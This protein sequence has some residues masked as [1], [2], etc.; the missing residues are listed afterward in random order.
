VSADLREP[1]ATSPVP[2]PP[3]SGRFDAFR[4][5]PIDWRRAMRIVAV[6]S[7]VVAVGRAIAYFSTIPDPAGSVGIDYRLYVAA[8]QRWLDS[9]TF[10]EPFQLAGPYH[11]QGIGEVLYPPIILWLLVPFTVLPAI[12]WWAI[13]IGLTAVAIARMRPAAWSVA[14]SGLICTTHAVQ[15]PLFWG[16]PVIWLAPAVAWGLLLGW[17]AVAVFVK[18]TLAPFALVGLTHPRAFVGGL[19]GFAILALP[20]LAMWFDWLTVVRNSDLGILYAYTQN[21]LLLVP[22]VAWLGR[23]GRLPGWP[24]RLRPRSVG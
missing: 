4:R 24:R 23:D 2:A 7:F 19:I 11:V 20:F 13:P 18:P 21:V 8:A 6:A 5:E 15:A 14:V 17:P 12:L 22:V 10:Y 9:G 16:T 1:S 3:A